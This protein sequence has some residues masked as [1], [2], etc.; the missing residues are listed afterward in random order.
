MG[1]LVGILVLSFYGVLGVA[2]P[3]TLRRWF[4]QGYNFDDPQKWYKPNTWLRPQPGVL[5][6]RVAGYVAMGLAMFLLYFWLQP[7]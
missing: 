6:F 2:F 4:L 1:L 3:Q 5:V 7:E